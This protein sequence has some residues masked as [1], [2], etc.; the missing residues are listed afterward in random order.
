MGIPPCIYLV[1]RMER[2]GGGEGKMVEKRGE[3]RRRG[4]LPCTRILIIRVHSQWT[5]REFETDEGQSEC[6]CRVISIN[7]DKKHKKEEKKKKE[8][9]N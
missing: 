1:I 5:W 7:N 3:E 9:G 8:E 6:I 2:R 4:E